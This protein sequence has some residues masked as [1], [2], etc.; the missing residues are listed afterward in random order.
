MRAREAMLASP[1][2][3]DDIGKLL[4]VVREGLSDSACLDNVLQLLV[5]GGR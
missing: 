4:P 2:F 5:Q 1:L 3:G